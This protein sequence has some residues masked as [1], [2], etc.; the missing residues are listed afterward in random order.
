MAIELARKLHPDVVLMDLSMPKFSGIE[1]TRII[2]EELPEVRVI[3]L[4]IF[5]D[6]EHEETMIAAGAAAFLPKSGPSEHIIFA[7]RA[8]MEELQALRRGT[9]ESPGA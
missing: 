1:A 4:S 5:D 9:K 7:I 6:S 3:A 2:H 8:C